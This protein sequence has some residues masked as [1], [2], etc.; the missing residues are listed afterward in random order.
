MPLPKV[1]VYAEGED[2]KATSA[3]LELLGP[4][5][6]A[7]RQAFSEVRAQ[8]G[9]GGASARAAEVLIGMLPTAAGEEARA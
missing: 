8:L 2:G 1:W 9:E 3:T 4:P 5:G 6:A 7:Q